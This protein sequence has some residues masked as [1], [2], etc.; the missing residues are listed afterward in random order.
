V[1][2]QAFPGP[3]AR[4]QI[5]TSDGQ[6]PKWSRNGK[7]LFYCTQDG[8]IMVVAYRVSGDSFVVEKPQLWSTQS[9]NL[10]NLGALSTFD[11]H[12]DGRRFAVVKALGPTDGPP[13]N[14]VTLISNFFDEVRRK[15]SA[16]KN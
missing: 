12:P 3:G 14:E 8:K 5:S 2:V 11:L 15:M 9:L 6:H 13:L 7:E 10:M 4:W 16:G 1:Y